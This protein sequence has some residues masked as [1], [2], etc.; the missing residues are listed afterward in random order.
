MVTEVIQKTTIK[1]IIVRKAFVKVLL[2][3]P[4]DLKFIRAAR[5]VHWLAEIGW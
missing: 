3:K 5:F 2:V 4:L 1:A